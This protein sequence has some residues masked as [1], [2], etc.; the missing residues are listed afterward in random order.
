MLS[1]FAVNYKLIK[2][3]E[4]NAKLSRVKVSG[5]KSTDSYVIV[6]ILRNNQ[7]WT[8]TTETKCTVYIL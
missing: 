8:D 7:L 3:G 6:V 2:F 5:R 1:K 4:M